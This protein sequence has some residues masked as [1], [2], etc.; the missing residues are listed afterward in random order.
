LLEGIEFNA[1]SQKK[2]SIFMSLTSTTRKPTPTRATLI[3]QTNSTKFAKMLF[4]KNHAKCRKQ[5]GL[6]LGL[7]Q[8]SPN[9]LPKK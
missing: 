4:V 7:N 8:K 6:N 2:I 1:L 5:V 9:E 3:N